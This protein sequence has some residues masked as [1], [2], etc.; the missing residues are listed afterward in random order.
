MKNLFKRGAFTL[1]ELLVV[2]AIIGILIAMLLPAVQAVRE[3]ARNTQCKNNIKQIALAAVNYE[4]GLMRFP[5]GML[6]EIDGLS[7]N[8]MNGR[9]QELGVLVHLLPFIEANNLADLIEPTLLNI[10]SYANDGDGNGFWG[11]FDLAGEANARFASI[12]QVPAFKCPS[13]QQETDGIILALGSF[14]N[15]ASSFSVGLFL[16]GRG[17]L[18]GDHGDA[19]IGTTNYVGVAGAVGQTSRRSFSTTL[20]PNH[21]GIFLNRSKTTFGEISDGSS[22]TFLFGEV[23]SNPDSRWIA[24]LAATSVSY[25]WMG[26]VLVA[27]NF[28]GG[29][30]T[31]N[32]KTL[33]YRSNHLGTVNFASADGSVR[34]APD[35]A[36]TN[37]M[38]NLSGKADGQTDVT[39]N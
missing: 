23:A 20:W 3:A 26:N 31:D 33:T 8:D 28:W 36:D 29:D 24:P 6:E 17:A 21:E 38:R 14:G 10:D 13:D 32:Q 11:E 37:V 1:V 39:I 16:A 30:L 34:S 22:N 4:S 15:D 18:I 35:S 7:E 27:M 19:P 12:H 9:G 2:I 5:P 25:A